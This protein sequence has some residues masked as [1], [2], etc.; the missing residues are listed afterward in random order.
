MFSPSSASQIR[1]LMTLVID[2]GQ[3]SI[4]INVLYAFKLG[5]PRVVI[6]L[7]EYSLTITLLLNEY[8]FS[9]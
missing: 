9:Q 1:L 4:V 6:L 7:L 3:T 8:S 2:K 5:L